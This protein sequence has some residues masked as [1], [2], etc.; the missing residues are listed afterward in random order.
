MWLI[1]YYKHKK[2]LSL[3]FYS[4]QEYIHMRNH[5][6]RAYPPHTHTAENR[7]RSFC[8]VHYE[9]I[10]YEILYNLQSTNGILLNI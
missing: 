7:L 3:H 1:G 5:R 4:T 8:E 6:Q 2:Q 10:K 9:K